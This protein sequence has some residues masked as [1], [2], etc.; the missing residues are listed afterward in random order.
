MKTAVLDANLVQKLVD[1]HCSQQKTVRELF[2][3]SVDQCWNFAW[4]ETRLIKHYR[5]VLL[6]LYSTW[7][8]IKND[9]ESKQKLVYTSESKIK[10]RPLSIKEEKAIKAVDSKDMLL[11]RIARGAGADIILTIEV[12]LRMIRKV[13]GI[14]VL[15]LEE[16]E[17]EIEKNSNKEI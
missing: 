11:F 14:R 5:P 16:W 7:D 17:K 4:H 3:R 8:R 13:E 6:S 9:L 2:L 1:P 12:R 15:D 10:A